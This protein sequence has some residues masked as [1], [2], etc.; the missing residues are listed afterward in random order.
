MMLS[1]TLL[2]IFPKVR[3]FSLFCTE[4]AVSQSFLVVYSVREKEDVRSFTAKSKFIERTVMFVVEE[5]TL[6]NAR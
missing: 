6:A 2:S 3:L 5:R 1:T 4:T